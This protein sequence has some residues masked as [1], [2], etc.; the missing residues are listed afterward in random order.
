MGTS[1]SAGEKVIGGQVPIVFAE[2]VHGATAKWV[3]A[4]NAALIKVFGWAKKNRSIVNV[5]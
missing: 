4:D 5:G 3:F 2:G 1:G